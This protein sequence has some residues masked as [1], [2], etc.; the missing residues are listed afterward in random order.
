MMS[1][2]VGR[3][4]EVHSCVGDSGNEWGLFEAAGLPGMHVQNAQLGDI[5]DK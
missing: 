4:R 5:V 2:D 3:W 1:E